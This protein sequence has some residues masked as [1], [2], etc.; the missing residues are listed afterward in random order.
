MSRKPDIVKVFLKPTAFRILLA[1]KN[2]SQE[3]FCR[4][5]DLNK[6]YCSEIV[7]GSRNASPKLRQTIQDK[8][9]V[10]FDD[11]FEIRTVVSKQWVPQ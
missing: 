8:L 11:I 4:S 1:R 9:E 10:A 2:L 6:T 5:I 7:V 3:A